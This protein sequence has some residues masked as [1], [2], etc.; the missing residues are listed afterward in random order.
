MQVSYTS[1]CM[2]GCVGVWVHVPISCAV[3]HWHVNYQRPACCVECLISILFLLCFF[4]IYL[5]VQ[6]SLLKILLRVWGECSVN[7]SHCCQSEYWN[8]DP[9]N[10]HKNWK[11]AQKA[12]PWVKLETLA[13]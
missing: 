4:L 1:V 7:M 10:P 3:T 9:Q 13:Q 6:K 5:F 2:C 11:G 8:S 12:G